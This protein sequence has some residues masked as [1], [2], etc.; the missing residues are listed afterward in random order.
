MEANMEYK[1]LLKNEIKLRETL[2]KQ[3][4]F[5]LDFFNDKRIPNSVKNEWSTKYNELNIERF[6]E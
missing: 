4:Q 5:I 6:N 3:N 1:Q 2:L